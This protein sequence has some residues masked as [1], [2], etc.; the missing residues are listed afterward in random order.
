VPELI[1]KK[2]PFFCAFFTSGKTATALAISLLDSA[3]FKVAI[4]D[5]IFVPL[6]TL[7][8]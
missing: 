2:C 6:G 7:D 4:A 1:I 8:I 3:G 5:S